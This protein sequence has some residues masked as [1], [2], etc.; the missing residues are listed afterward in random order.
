MFKLSIK[1]NFVAKLTTRNYI[2]YIADNILVL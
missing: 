2:N 1:R